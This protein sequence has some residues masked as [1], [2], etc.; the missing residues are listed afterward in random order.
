MYQQIVVALDGTPEAER[1]LP[2]VEALAK[3]FASKVELVWATESPEMIVAET[4]PV[5]SPDEPGLPVN[6]LPLVEQEH[7]D[8]A[9]YLASIAE[10]LRGQGILVSHE[11]PEGPPADVIL[12]TADRLGADLIA[13]TTHARGAIGRL[14]LGSIAGDVIRHASCPVLVIRRES[15]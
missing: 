12:G 2:H 1:I 3:G 5:S 10:R 15:T 6:P 7:Q 4:I 9:A 11:D 8:A 14:V 13:L